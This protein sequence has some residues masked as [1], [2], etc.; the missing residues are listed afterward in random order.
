MSFVSPRTAGT[1][2]TQQEEAIQLPVAPGYSNVPLLQT[3]PGM[4]EQCDLE[5][6]PLGHPAAQRISQHMAKESLQRPSEHFT[7]PLKWST[8][9]LREERNEIKAETGLYL[10]T[11]APGDRCHLLLPCLHAY[12]RFIAAFLPFEMWHCKAWGWENRFVIAFKHFKCALYASNFPRGTCNV[13]EPT[14][15]REAEQLAQ[16]FACLV[17]F[18]LNERESAFS[19]FPFFRPIHLFI[20]GRGRKCTKVFARQWGFQKMP[21]LQWAT[22][23]CR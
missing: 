21:E 11:W 17:Q 22:V 5:T 3:T 13:R 15:E 12:R 2:R 1:S 10:E 16:H 7:S 6:Q 9:S 8:D 19:P 18:V 14:E 4:L 23:S 20:S